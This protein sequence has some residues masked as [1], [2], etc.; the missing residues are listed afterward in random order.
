MLE[1]NKVET[2]TV[3]FFTIAVLM[4]AVL[5]RTKPLFPSK[6]LLPEVFCACSPKGHRNERVTESCG[7][8]TP[9]IT[10]WLFPLWSIC[11]QCGGFSPGVSHIRSWQWEE[12]A[13]PKC[14]RLW[15]VRSWF[16]TDCTENWSTS[17]ETRVR[18]CLQ[19]SSLA[20]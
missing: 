11:T 3:T 10:C 20:S 9:E 1:H 17:P 19:S 14:P 16:L 18:S 15:E 7:F 2:S 12:G 13:G 8:P 6:Q 4:E 5:A